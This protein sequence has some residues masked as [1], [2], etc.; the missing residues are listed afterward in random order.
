MKNRKILGF[1]GLLVLA[2]ATGAGLAS[3]GSATETFMIWGPEEHRSMY[4]SLGDEFKKANPSFPGTFEY[5]ASGDAG[6]YSNMAKDPVAGATIY[7]F[8]NDMLNNLNRLGALAPLLNDNLTWAQTK[9]NAASFESGKIGDR[10]YGYPIQADNGYYM[11]YRK[12]VFKDSVA[13]D[14]ATGGLK[15]GYTFRDLYNAIDAKAASDS[16]LSDAKVTW[17]I[18]D[19]W[20][21]SG[22]FFA[23]GGDYN[24]TYDSS[25]SQTAAKCWFSYDKD[26]DSAGAISIN[27]LNASY[28]MLNSI[29]DAPAS[30]RKGTVLDK[31]FMFSDG[32]K[33]PLNDNI[34]KYASKDASKNNGTPL[35]AAVCGTW[36]AKEIQTFW[37]DDYAATF[38]P[39]LQCYDDDYQFK[40]FCGFKLMGVNP[41]SS[42][43]SKDVDHLTWAHKVAQFMSDKE[44]Q[45]DRYTLT[46]AGPSNLEAL[47]DDTIKADVALKALNAQYD[48]VCKY[49][50]NTQVVDA[51]N[52][53]VAGQVIGNGLGY[54]IQDSVPANYWTPLASFGNS[55]YN[56]VKSGTLDKFRTDGNIR[57]TTNQLQADV[58]AASV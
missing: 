19:A 56:E 20:Y 50:A 22:C 2:I 27:G 17:A 18:G 55:L 21:V 23:V 43:A 58:Q 32:D 33:Q 36:K 53:S 6:A 49:P 8:A 24:V 28:G 42:F 25:G 15:A 13:W 29:T 46:G 31:H 34:S 41:L 35:V 39:K 10:Y 1:G 12:D 4:V 44:S 40:N 54:R 5:A 3:C 57:R 9:N 45:I 26:I 16:S 7:T 14:S 30:G 38:L 48:Y 37:G 52:K 47:Q 11:Y 51:S